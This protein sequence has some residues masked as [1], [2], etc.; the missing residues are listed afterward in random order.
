MSLE[1]KPYHRQSKQYHAAC[2]NYCEQ[3]PAIIWF[4]LSDIAV[5][6]VRT[7][8]AAREANMIRRRP[9]QSQNGPKNSVEIRQGIR[10]ASTSKPRRRGLHLQRSNHL[11]F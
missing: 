8:K 6:L 3:P 7:V 11:W 2:T 9:I 4:A 5:R 10:H 1:Q